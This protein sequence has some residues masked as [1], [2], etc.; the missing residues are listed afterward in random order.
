MAMHPDPRRAA[1]AHSSKQQARVEAVAAGRKLVA[2]IDRALQEGR[3]R[4]EA[5]GLDYRAVAVG[6]QRRYGPGGA[7]RLREEYDKVLSAID[8]TEQRLRKRFEVKPSNDGKS[9]RPRSMV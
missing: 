7:A 3:R 1:Q 4:F 8:G 6:L 2:D 9:R 5:L